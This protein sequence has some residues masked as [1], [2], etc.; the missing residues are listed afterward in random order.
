MKI[1]IRYTDSFCNIS[2]YGNMYDLRSAEDWTFAAPKLVE[3]KVIKFDSHLISLGIAMELPKYFEAH[4]IARSSLFKT[5]GLSLVNGIGEIDGPDE[6]NPGYIG[7]NDIWHA[8]LIAT[9][10]GK[11]S[12]GMRIC[13]FRIQ[14]CMKAPWWVKVKWLFTSTIEFVEVNELRNKD[15]GGHGTSGIN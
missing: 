2:T 1:R 3:N 14:P 6:D 7:N 4:V 9:R 15:R 13:Q 10:A 11:I 5:T 12:K 8:H